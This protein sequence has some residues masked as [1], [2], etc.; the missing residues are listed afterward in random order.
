MP[1]QI[2]L[3]R[4]I[5]LGSRNRVS[6]PELRDLL[7]E[8][9]YGDVRTLVQSGN[10]VLTSRRSPARLEKDLQR[11]IA[12]GLGV[13]TPVIVRTRDELAAVIERDP[14]GAEVDNPKLYQ[15]TFLASEP[16]AEAAR[17]LAEADVAPERLELIG[18]ELYTWH[19]DGIQRSKVDRLRTSK[20]LPDGTARNW[21]TVTGLLE[22]ADE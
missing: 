5:N 12:D 11:E 3:L 9:G 17:E 16:S 14:F 21:N 10:V 8:L 7:T 15:V 6:M 4:G 20:R 18:R 2:A 19:P 13:D 22:L 1:R